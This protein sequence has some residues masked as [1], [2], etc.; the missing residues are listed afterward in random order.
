MWRLSNAVSIQNVWIGC[1]SLVIVD[2]GTLSPT[3]GPTLTRRSVRCP[4]AIGPWAI[5]PEHEHRVI[6]ARRAN[7]SSG[8]SP[9]RERDVVVCE[10]FPEDAEAANRLGAG[11]TR[12]HLINRGYSNDIR[13]PL[14]IKPGL[15]HRDF[16]APLPLTDV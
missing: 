10:L 15:D 4:I 12:A 8:Y 16:A 14:C 5:G 6:S 13:C 9:R 1:V 3:F 11:A 7:M 2:D